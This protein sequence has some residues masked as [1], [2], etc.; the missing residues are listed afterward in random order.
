M[1]GMCEE[2]LGGKRRDWRKDKEGRKKSCNM[3]ISVID[4]A[5][6]K[7]NKTIKTEQ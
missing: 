3:S 5:Q 1:P 2:A 6:S 4:W 7:I